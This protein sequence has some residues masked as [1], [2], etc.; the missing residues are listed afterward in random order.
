[1][2]VALLGRPVV[3]RLDQYLYVTFAFGLPLPRRLQRRVSVLVEASKPLPFVVVFAVTLDCPIGHL[4]RVEPR[5]I[6]GTAI[7]LLRGTLVVVGRS[8][9]PL[10]TVGRVVESVQATALLVVHTVPTVAQHLKAAT[11]S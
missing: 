7:M 1:M 11:L 10:G 4:G 9:R 6:R 2:A 5:P 3:R 8:V